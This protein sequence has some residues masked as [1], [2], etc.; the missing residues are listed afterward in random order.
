MFKGRHVH[1]LSCV[2]G[3]NLGPDLVNKHGVR[4]FI[5]YDNLFVYGT[6]A[7]GATIPGPCEP[8]N[9]KADF[10]SFNDS[11]CEGERAII[12]RGKSVGEARD[13]IEKKFKEYIDKYTKGE[14]KDRPVASNAVIFLRHDL[15]HLKAYGDMNF[16]PCPSA[17]VKLE[18]FPYI[19]AAGIASGLLGGIISGYAEDIWKQLGLPT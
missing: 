6:W 12:L 17:P 2:T 9:P 3:K 11:D 4:S 1:L 8:P 5:G 7:R 13:A 18:M 19:L 16:V 15:A 14:W 10:S